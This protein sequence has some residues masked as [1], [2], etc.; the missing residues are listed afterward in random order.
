MLGYDYKVLIPTTD[1]QIGNYD[2]YLLILYSL[3]Y[4][5]LSALIKSLLYG[6]L[7][8]ALTKYA[9]DYID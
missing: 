5:Y 1:T 6:Y 9:F 2:L 4:L 3:L 8:K 7:C